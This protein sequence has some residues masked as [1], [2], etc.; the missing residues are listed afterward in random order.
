MKRILSLVATTLLVGA[1]FFSC[2]S[3]DSPTSGDSSTSENAHIAI[4]V[5]TSDISVTKTENGNYITF[6]ADVCDTYRWLLNETEL[7]AGQSCVIDTASL[8]KGTYTLSLEAQKGGSWYSYFA[9]I[10]VSK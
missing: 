7:S 4:T 10:T 1:L 2:S 3:G 8:E 5:N 9:Q 6:T